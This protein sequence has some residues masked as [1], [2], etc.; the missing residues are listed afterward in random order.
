MAEPVGDPLQVTIDRV[1]PSTIPTRGRITLSGTITNTSDSVWNDLNVYLLTS[2]E[3]MRTAQE[4][5][6]AAALDPLAYVGDRLA[7]AGQF[8]SVPDLEPGQSTRY[9][10]SRP[11]DE[12]DITD[13]PGVYWVGVQVLGADETGR[14]DGAD[15]RAR[16]FIPLMRPRN[17]PSTSLALMLPFRGRI[18]YDADGRLLTE[19]VWHEA[20]SPEGR[21]GRLLALSQSAGDYPLTWVVDPAVAD[22]VK[23]VAT[24]N[25]GWDIAPTTDESPSS[26]PTTDESPSGDPDAEEPELSQEALAAQ[27]F[28]EAFAQEAA[29]RLVLAL[30]YGDVDAASAYG[31]ERGSTVEEA[32]ALSQETLDALDIASTPV[33]DPTDGTLSWDALSVIGDSVPV[34]LDDTAL[35]ATE[36]RVDV[37]DGARIT[38]TSTAA[39][40]EL[41]GTSP[42]LG[43]RQRVLAE[44]AVHALSNQADRP[45]VVELPD[46]WD[47]G[48]NW[49]RAAL[50]RGLDVPWLVGTTASSIVRGVATATIEANSDELRYPEDAATLPSSNFISSAE[51]IRQG[52]ILDDLLPR[53]NRIARVIEGLAYLGVSGQFLDVP[54]RAEERAKDQDLR[55][56]DL[57]G[58]VTLSGP[59]FVTMSSENGE[60]QVTVTNELDEPVT[61]GISAYAPGTDEITIPT[62]EPIT[63]PAGQRRSVRMQANSERIGLWPVVLQAVTAEGDPLGDSEGLNIR[64]SHVGMVVWSVLGAGTVVLLVLIFFRVRRKVRA[65]QATP[66]PLLK[67]ADS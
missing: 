19:D 38:R 5:A 30:P 15:G 31:W 8:I 27:A 35:A 45:L 18:S 40:Q 43:F 26:S 58:Q 2:A 24:D 67:E 62:T 7:Q 57:M 23:A 56:R 54:G 4:L 55:V 65:R 14:I 17:P 10:I 52:G 42:A 32:H 63:I 9:T 60:F 51:L 39:V 64:S 22:L 48:R 47:P 6:E 50:F 34:V 46:R 36:P 25:P 13:Q 66:G 12:L 44:A 49:Q 11:R 3:P 33:I 1:G 41:P 59:S 53:N 16:T 37:A 61:V 21:F 28:L 29:E 20:L